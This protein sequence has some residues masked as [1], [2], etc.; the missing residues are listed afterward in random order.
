MAKRVRR[1]T[2]FLLSIGISGGGLVVYL[3]TL[4]CCAFPGQSARLIVQHGGL[5]PLVSPDRPLWGVLF[6]MVW[7]L[8]FGNAVVNVNAMSAVCGA[9]GVWLIIN[10]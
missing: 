10:C 1:F 2:G 7:S 6:R 5:S 9:I 8:P 3:A 4:S